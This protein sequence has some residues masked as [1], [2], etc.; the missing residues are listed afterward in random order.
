MLNE[1]ELVEQ[2]RELVRKIAE[3][4][5]KNI[6]LKITVDK[7]SDSIIINIEEYNI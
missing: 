6:Q 4:H 7:T 5:K 1:A 3:F 2:L